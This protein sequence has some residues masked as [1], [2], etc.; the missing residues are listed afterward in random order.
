MKYSGFIGNI[1]DLLVLLSIETDV[2]C[3]ETA[4][5]ISGLT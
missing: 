3:T 2:H 4:Q 5:K 1:Q